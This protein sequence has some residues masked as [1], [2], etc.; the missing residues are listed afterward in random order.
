MTDDNI[1]TLNTLVDQLNSISEQLYDIDRTL[2]YAA[3]ELKSEL[4]YMAK[5]ELTLSKEGVA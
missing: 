4:E 1:N 2:F 3:S 5:V